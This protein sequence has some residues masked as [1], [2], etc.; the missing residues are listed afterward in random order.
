M[1]V[2]ARRND[3]NSR[4]CCSLS[5]RLQ[6]S[7]KL[8]LLHRGIQCTGQWPLWADFD[9]PDRGLFLVKNNHSFRGS[10]SVHVNA[11]STRIRRFC[12]V[13]HEENTPMSVGVERENPPDQ[14]L[15]AQVVEMPKLLESLGFWL[16]T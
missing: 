8:V 13:G 9:I 3:V 5:S 15:G 16:I 14:R 1:E 12:A 7:A 6:E 10:C 4:L 11:M 2:L